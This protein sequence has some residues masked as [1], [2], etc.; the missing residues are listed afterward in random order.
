MNFS[1]VVDL[2]GGRPPSKSE[3]DSCNIFGESEKEA[4]ILL[5]GEGFDRDSKKFREWLDEVHPEISSRVSILATFY[6]GI[7]LRAKDS[8]LGHEEAREI[9]ETLATHAEFWS[10]GVG[11]FTGI[12]D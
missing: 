6:N 4:Y 8:A 11:T 12:P 3:F 1:R 7:Y 9:A 5:D 10:V 2:D